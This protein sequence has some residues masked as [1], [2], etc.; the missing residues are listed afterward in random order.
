MGIRRTTTLVRGLATALAVCIAL[1]PARRAFPAPGD[2]FTQ[3]AP[4]IGSDPP[5]AA[6]LATGD[7]SVATSTGAATYSYPIRVPPGRNGVAPKLLASTSAEGQVAL[8]GR[9]G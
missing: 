9:A 5:K 7:V 1:L 6:D 2:I 4:V 8:S 3:P